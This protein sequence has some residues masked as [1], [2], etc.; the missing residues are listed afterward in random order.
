[1]EESVRKVDAGAYL[2]A[3][4][5]LLREGKEVSLVVTGNSM[6]PFLVHGRDSVILAKADGGWKK[7]DIA[8]FQRKT[9]EYILH[10]ISR[11]EKAGACFFIGDGQLAEEGPIEPEQILGRVIAAR[12]KGKWEKPGTFLWDFFERV[13]LRMIPLRPLCLRIYRGV[14]RKV[15]CGRVEGR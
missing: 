12:R 15:R 4:E 13:W 8:L 7:G 14:M 6:S 11:V 5:A 9:S 1:M 2:S 3:L 10:R